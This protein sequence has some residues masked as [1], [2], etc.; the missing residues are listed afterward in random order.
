MTRKLSILLVLGLLISCGFR[1][2][3]SLPAPSISKAGS[4]LSILPD[5][6][7]EQ[8]KKLIASDGVTGNEFGGSISLSG[9]TLVVGAL[10]RNVAYV[11]ERN[12]GGVDN[13]GQIAELS[14]PDSTKHCCFGS[15]VT[16]SVDTLVV[17]AYGNAFDNGGAAYV[18]ERNRG[19]A[20]N[21]GLV[22]ELTGSDPVSIN[23]F[24]SSLS[25]S[26]STL[27]VGSLGADGQKGVAYVFERNHGGADRWGQIARLV[28]S[29]PQFP[30]F[31][32]RSVSI[33]DDTLVVGAYGTGSFHGAAYVFERNHGGADHWGQVARLIGSTK[34]LNNSQ[35]GFSVS[36]SGDTLVVGAP[37]K[38]SEEGAA[39][40][41][42]RNQGGA[43]RW[44]QVVELTG[45]N[46]AAGDQ[47]GTSVAVDRD[48]LL[49]GAPYRDSSRGAMYFFERDQGGA[50]KWGQVADVTLPEGAEK[51]Y[52]GGSMSLSDS[53]F[54]IGA[55]GRQS[56]RG[57]AY[58]YRHYDSWGA[59]R[60]LTASDP[61][62]GDFG[63]ATS[64]S[65][66][67]FAVG[68]TG[69]TG[70][71]YLFERNHGG[72]DKWGQVKKVVPSD[73]VSGEVL[74]QWVTLS[75]DTLVVGSYQQ[76]GSKS[77][78]YVFER[79]RGGA[80]NWGQVKKITPL[81][82]VAD[83]GFGFSVALS[84][85]ILLVGTEF[86]GTAYV[87]E[88]NRGGADQWGQV[89]KL[90]APDPSK[91]DCFGCFVSLSGDTAV[92]GAFLKNDDHGAAYVF[93]RN[94]GGADNWGQ[95][96]KLNPS[97]P[98]APGNFGFSVSIDGDQLVVGARTIADRGAAYVFH[99][100][101]GGPDSWGQVVKLTAPDAG[102]GEG[103]G[104]S[105]GLSGD[106]LVVGA[107]RD[108][109]AKG[110][111]YV[112][113]RD[114][115]GADH[116]GQIQELTPINPV[117]EDRFGWAVALSGTTLGVGAPTSGSNTGV[118]YVFE[119]R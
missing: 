117:P 63:I 92:V 74:G 44:G 82:P 114:H 58:V 30:G 27:V 43:D 55:P 61:Q 9:D 106:T 46:S 88:R 83:S 29:D 73:P 22:T 8:V 17:G 64:L 26:G 10:E 91:G 16:L 38:D 47:F 86:D 19:G 42:E 13:W 45:S 108:D 21:W 3:F 23:Y 33:S 69:G 59:V 54:V 78:V 48:T 31:F 66:D 35:F 89:N 113:E 93:E 90:T 94:H 18:F 39:Y 75:G 32:G 101:R 68:C 119:Q 85:D 109:G 41:F 56:E 53:T 57:E 118:A 115:G 81:E 87:F 62:P 52:F 28:A 107:W 14:S 37:E 100:D 84:D 102:I 20:D 34:N 67:T 98:K 60:I 76:N 51:D 104:S 116:W 40:V 5:R 7:M 4:D 71:V 24:G 96:K 36:I 15:A 112:F 11:F 50:N 6:K 77:A 2:A 1:V 110:A 79:N 103:F 95:V 72:A 97:D 65:G 99:R 49:V 12:H 80:D 105:V 70:A 111:V 25:L